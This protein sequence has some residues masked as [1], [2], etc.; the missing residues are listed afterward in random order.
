MQINALPFGATFLAQNQD[1]TRV[2]TSTVPGATALPT[3]LLRPYPGYG[4]IRMWDYSGYGNYHSLQTGINRRYDNGFM[5]SFFYVWSKALGHQ[6]HGLAR[7]ACRTSSEEETRRLDYSYTDY[8]RPHNFVDQLRLPDAGS[9][10][11]QGDRPAHQQLAGLRRVSLDQ[12]PSVHRRLQHPRHRRRQPD[13]HRWQPQRPHRPDLRP[14]R[15]LERRP[16]RTVQHRRAS[17][18]RSLAATAP[19]RRGSS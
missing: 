3:D 18:R 16:V 11:V 14:G 1:P 8:D 2:G 13:R 10:R 7:P 9:E 5:F 12:R 17:R 19:S 4:G 6:Q 15:W